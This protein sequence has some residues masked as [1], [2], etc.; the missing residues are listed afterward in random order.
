MDGERVRYFEAL[1]LLLFLTEAGY[2]RQSEAGIVERLFKTTPFHQ[3][4]ALRAM[5]RRFTEI[6]GVAVA[7]P[8]KVGR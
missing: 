4:A 6:S 5:S 3:A 1:R 7:L 8:A 2:Y